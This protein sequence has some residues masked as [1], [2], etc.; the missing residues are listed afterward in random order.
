M[1]PLPQVRSNNYVIR[2]DYQTTMN[3]VEDAVRVYQ[4][5]RQGGGVKPPE[6][7]P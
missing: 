7:Q 6:K 1:N 3:L 4:A 2:V 5:R